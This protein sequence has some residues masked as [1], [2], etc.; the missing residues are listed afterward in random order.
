MKDAWI[1]AL[2]PAVSWWH[3]NR[4]YRPAQSPALVNLGS[5]LTYVPGW[6]NIDAGLYS[7][8]RKLPVSLLRALYRRSQWKQQMSAD[9]YVWILKSAVFYQYDL[10]RGIPFADSSLDG[11]HSAHLVDVFGEDENA[12]FFREVLR[13]LKPGAI[14]RI[15]TADLAKMFEFYQGGKR[16]RRYATFS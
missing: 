16:M 3:R 8:F 11:L 7:W 14:V 9:A 12:R 6:I 4:R 1:D 2:I 10:R 15:S 5:G 13:V